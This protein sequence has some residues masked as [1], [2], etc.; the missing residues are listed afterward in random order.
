[1]PEMKAAVLVEPGRFEI[2]AVPVPTV[3]PGDA[4]IRVHRCGIC[5]TDVHIF[6]GQYSADR[7]PLIPGHD[8]AGTIAAVGPEVDGL[9]VGGRAV[10]DINF[11]CGTCFT[12]VATRC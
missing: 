5:G 9:A 11:G 1:M 2:S 10:V 8:L 6:N 12:A 3:G 4:L 7:L